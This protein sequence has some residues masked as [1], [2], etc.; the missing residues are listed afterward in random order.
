[1]IKVLAVPWL[2]R[3]A[4]VLSPRVPGFDLKPVNV[5]FVV[6]RVSLG[7]IF[8]RVRRFLL[9]HAPHIHSSFT[10]AV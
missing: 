6:D 9:C 4:A 10:D 1:M 3:S 8:L 7:Q 5:G 2:R